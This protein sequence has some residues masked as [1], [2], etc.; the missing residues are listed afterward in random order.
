MP[1]SRAEE[2]KS[3]SAVED[4]ELSYVH[5][6]CIAGEEDASFQF[7]SSRILCIFILFILEVYFLF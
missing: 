6:T 3:T 4:M 1:T 7:S 2:G 5:G